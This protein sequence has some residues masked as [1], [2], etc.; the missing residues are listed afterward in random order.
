M[1]SLPLHP[2]TRALLLWADRE[3]GE[4]AY[5]SEGDRNFVD[6]TAVDRWLADRA[7]R[8]SGMC[9]S[10]VLIRQRLLAAKNDA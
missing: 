10:M 6:V 8:L 4:D 3:V 7:L 1:T 5:R 9:S 2:E